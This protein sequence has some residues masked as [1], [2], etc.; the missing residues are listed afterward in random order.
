MEVQLWL[1]VYQILQHLAHP[2]AKRQQYSDRTILLVL[3][4]AVLWRRPISWVCQRRNWPPCLQEHLLNLPEDSTMS[5][6]MRT[7]PFL[8]LLERTMHYLMDLFPPQL[9][10][11]LDAMPLRVGG[12]SKDGDATRGKAAG[13]M[14]RGY[15]LHLCTHGRMP[16]DFVLRPMNEHESKAAV[17]LIRNLRGYG[18]AVA[19]NAYDANDLH[20]AAA[21]VGHQL[22]SPA[23][24]SNQGVRDVEHNYPARLRSLDLLDSP[25]GHCGQPSRFG[26]ELYNQRVAIESCFGE[27]S[28]LGLDHLPAW[29]RRPTRV[30]RWVGAVL[31]LHLVKN[32]HRHHRLP[33]YK[34]LRRR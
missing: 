9:V 7:V 16:R 18:Y 30:A 10:K 32:A 31:I 24:P 25:L 17:E 33:K 20:Q 14:A 34:D 6:R 11:Q 3:V 29:V 26:Q 1:L 4:W 13:Q 23:R 21:A 19:D 12:F 28:Y 8:Q 27:L 22:V 2:P 5:R 15:K